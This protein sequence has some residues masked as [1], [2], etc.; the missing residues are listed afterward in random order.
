M[1]T[2]IWGNDGNGPAK[3]D[4]FNVLGATGVTLR[5]CLVE[6]FT[7]VEL[8]TNGMGGAGNLDGT[9][10]ANDPG[11]LSPVDPALSPFAGGDLRLSFGS[12]AI[13]QGL[14]ATN[15]STVDLAGEPRI[16]NEIIDLGAYESD[17]APPT[18]LSITTTETSPSN[19]TN[20]TFQVRFSEAVVGFDAF[21]DLVLQVVGTANAV[22]A[23][24]TGTGDTYTVLLTGITGSGSL[25]IAVDP[26][27]DVEDLT[28]NALASSLT[29]AVVIIDNEAELS[30]DEV[31]GNDG[32]ITENEFVAGISVAGTVTSIE[33]GQ[34][35]CVA[36][37]DANNNTV[38]VSTVVRSNLTW[39]IQAGSTNLFGEQLLVNRPNQE[40]DPHL[41]GLPD[42]G[43]V[44]VWWISGDG[45]DGSDLEIYM[46]RNAADGEPMGGAVKVDEPDGDNDQYPKV[47]G[48]T[49]GGWVVVWQSVNDFNDGSDFE[50]SMQRYDG[51]GTPVGTNT[52]VNAPDSS[53]DGVPYVTG[54]SDGGWLVTWRGAGEGGDGADN[55]I[56]VQRYDALGARV[57][58]ELKMDDP[59]GNGTDAGPVVA[60]L[61][62]G[63]WVFAWQGWDVASG[64]WDVFYKRFDASGSNL[65]SDLSVN[66]NALDNTH[67]VNAKVVGLSNGGWV[68]TWRPNGPDSIPFKLFD[69][70]G[71]LINTGQVIQT[72]PMFNEWYETASLDDGGFLVTW[73]ATN[74]AATDPEIYVQRYDGMGTPIGG[75]TRIS[76]DDLGFDGRADAAL[77][78]NKGWIVAWENGGGLSYQ[79]FK[80][81]GSVIA[82]AGSMVDVSGLTE[83]PVTVFA[84]ASDRLGNAANDTA[85]AFLDRTAPVVIEV[86][87]DV[88]GNVTTASL[89]WTVSF[90]EPVMNFNDLA[91]LDLAITGSVTHTGFSVVDLG[92]G[93]NYVVTLSGLSG[94]GYIALGVRTN[95]DVQDPA[96]QMLTSTVFS[97]SAFLIDPATTIHYTDETSTNPVS[98][99][100]SWAT[101]ATRLQDALAFA[102][103]GDQV[104][105]A[106]GT[107]Y[108]DRGAFQTAGNRSATFA[109]RSNLDIYGGF[110]PGGS[111]FAARDTNPFSNN[112]VLSGDIHT[113]SDPPNN[114]YH[115]VSCIGSVSNARLDGFTI[116]DGYANG[117]GNDGFGAGLFASG[118]GSPLFANCRFSTNVAQQHGGGA[119]NLNMAPVFTNST[120][121]RNSA[122]SGGGA[123]NRAA[124]SG[125]YQCT[126]IENDADAG[127][128]LFINFS[129]LRVTNGL[130]AGNQA[131]LNGGAVYVLLSSPEFFNC[132]FAGNVAQ[133]DGGAL[134]LTDSDAT[135]INNTLVQNSA[136]RGGGIYSRS[137][138]PTCINTM[139]WSNRAPTNASP[140]S[141]SVEV[142]S[143]SATWS[144]C[145]VEHWTPAALGG[146]GHLDG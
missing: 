122:D 76:D 29:S 18:V 127:G 95:S 80:S 89:M 13:D 59:D 40:R 45:S 27:S 9:L 42:G 63:D 55:E 20:L 14:N 91:D 49:D 54:L 4:S 113:P 90:S 144:N 136:E 118:S 66:T 37:E 32:L 125:F 102:S 88:V 105:V 135:L 38:K 58:G 11:F 146:S 97:A 60:E 1:N 94:E 87:A 35:V 132:A 67:E 124:H 83:G 116:R 107:Y 84:S 64:N 8:N 145:L 137:S 79:R 141:L 53:N 7:A 106:E 25:G 62:G 61:A 47:A 71:S 65:T 5:H 77:L 82:T 10:P 3:Q 111:A 78:E 114:A 31:A 34:S 75:N 140:Q 41:A 56:Y 98:P 23:T 96:G 51:T 26:G 139:V 24:V 44:T 28:G 133:T 99:Y 52:M 30:I 129:D 69:A 12:P 81:D 33:P 109:L 121:E 85:A 142:Q 143:G 110:P 104:H 16:Q 72:G 126:F 73:N 57:G 123:Y 43:W 103:P 86:L 36:F 130:F 21:A 46:Q 22:G 134:Y 74:G 101:A 112:T 50:I 120:F 15:T 115:V 68:V 100:S 119:Y 19:A 93:S 138:N 48:L 2:I 117:T 92:G 108:P 128:A 17:S 131:V 6:H 39:E 70:A